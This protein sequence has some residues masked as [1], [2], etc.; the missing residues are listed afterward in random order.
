MMIQPSTVKRKMATVRFSYQNSW[1]ILPKNFVTAD[2]MA[3]MTFSANA[4]NDIFHDNVNG[5][6][7]YLNPNAFKIQDVSPESG[8]V[9]GGMT[10]AKDWLHWCTRY[11][12]Y[13]TLESKISITVQPIGETPATATEAKWPGILS[14]YK[15]GSST[16]DSLPDPTGASS[17][18][19]IARFPYCKQARFKGGGDAAGAGLKAGAYISMPY[20][21]KSFEGVAIPR[22]NID[23][24]GSIGTNP[25]GGGGGASPGQRT[26]FVVC[27]KNAVA[28]PADGTFAY[29]GD[30]IMR[31]KISYVVRFTEPT[32]VTNIPT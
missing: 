19:D 13:V 15:T 18:A 32:S 20:S 27:L 23:L 8:T 4:A 7:N 16:A 29:M 26:R 31:V 17:N 12:H 5:Y 6:P 9:I 21:A 25:G 1:H 22:D 30:S 10:L 14:V 3:W 28:T 11:Q 24:K 2:Q